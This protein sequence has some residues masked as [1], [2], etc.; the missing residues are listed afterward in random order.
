MKKFIFIFALLLFSA[1]IFS[2][3]YGNEWI[4]FNKTYYKIKVGKSGIYR[5][6]YNT[7]VS[8]GLPVDSINANQ[9]QLFYMGKQVPIY[10]TATGAMT[11]NDTIEFF[12]Q[13]NDGKY[14]KRL[15]ADSTWHT[16]DLVSMFSDTAVYFLTWDANSSSNERVTQFIND[17]TNPPAEE[18]Y[19]LYK[20]QNTYGN[21]IGGIPFQVISGYDLYSSEFEMAEGISKHA[22]WDFKPL[23]DMLPKTEDETIY[24]PFPYSSGDATLRTNV[25]SLT[26]DPRLVF[27]GTRE[28]D[29]NLSLNGN[30]LFNNIRF[31][32]TSLI[33]PLSYPFPVSFLTSINLPNS[34]VTFK[35]TSVYPDHYTLSWSFIEIEYPRLLNLDGK[36]TLRFSLPANGITS[37]RFLKFSNFGGTAVN[38]FLYDLTNKQRMIGIDDGSNNLLFVLSAPSNPNID[39]DI[40]LTYDET[41][42]INQLEAVQFKNFS[43]PLNQGDYIII[44][45]KELSSGSDPVQEYS[46]YRKS[47]K[48]GSY[49]P[50]IVDI[51]QL[52]DQFAYGIYRHPLSIHNFVEFALDSFSTVPQY[53]FMIGKGIDYTKKGQPGY[54]SIC[55]VPS[56]GNP[57][58]DVLL[59]SDFGR[60]APKL[61]VGR[62]SAY[63]TQD[64]ANYLKKVQAFDEN[65]INL[66][67]KPDN[68]DGRGFMKNIL[69][70][71][72]G[73]PN[74]QPTFKNY[75]QNYES[76]IE[77]TLFGGNVY[78]FFKTSPDP[79]SIAP[80]KF[81]DSLISSGLSIINF[82]GH[83]NANTFDF[84]ID[85]PDVYTNYGKYF[86]LISNGCYTGEIFSFETNVNSERFVLVEDKG[87]IAYLSSV[88]YGVS[89]ALDIFNTGLYEHLSRKSFGQSVGKCLQNSLQEIDAIYIGDKIV[90][91][92]AEQ[93]AYHGDPAISFQFNPLKQPD[94]Y[95]DRDRI[96]FSPSIISAKDSSFD[97]LVKVFNL[98]KAEGD[99]IDILI[100]RDMPGDQYDPL[101]LYFRVPATK[102]EQTYIVNLPRAVNDTL[103]DD[104]IGQNI[105]DIEIDGSYE[106]TEYDETNNTVS[107][108]LDILSNDAVPV[109]P[110]QFSIVPSDTVSLYA[111]VSNAISQ[112]SRNYIME[113]DTM[114]VG[115]LG[116]FNS[117]VKQSIKISSK[118]GV[119]QWK[120]KSSGFNFNNF[121]DSTVFYWRVSL[122]DSP[123]TWKY[124]SFIYLKNSSKGWNQSHYYQFKKD[125]FENMKLDIDIAS[126]K[127]QFISDAMDIG[128][129]NFVP[130]FG[131]T[132]LVWD[133][134][135]S[136]NGFRVTRGAGYI[137]SA[138]KSSGINFAIIDSATGILRKS[139]PEI[140]VIDPNFSE[141]FYSYGPTWD[142]LPQHYDSTNLDGTPNYDSLNKH[143]VIRFLDQQVKKGDYLL[144]YFINYQEPI[145]YNGN[146]DIMIKKF[147]EFGIKRL[148]EVFY[149]PSIDS[150]ARPYVFFAQKGHPDSTIEII[151][152]YFK[153]VIDTHFTIPQIWYQGSFQSDKIGPASNWRSLHWRHNGKDSPGDTILLSVYGIDKNGNDTLFYKFDDTQLDVGF[154]SGDIDAK[155][156]P[157]LRLKLEEKDDSMKTATQLKYWRVLYD[158]LPEAALNSNKNF[159]FEKDTLQQ[160]EPMKFSIA[161]ENISQRNMDSMLVRYIFTK[162]NGGKIIINKTFAPLLVNDTVHATFDTTLKSADF[163][164]RNQFFID[165]NPDNNQPEQFHFNNIGYKDFWV[166]GDYYNPLM[167]VTFDGYH[168]MDGDIVSA[169]PNIL[170]KLKDE[171]KYLALDDTSDFKITLLNPDKKTYYPLKFDNIVMRFTPADPSRLDKDNTAQIELNPVLTQ[172]GKYELVVSAT[173]KVGNQ[174]GRLDYKISFEVINRSMITN[175]LNYPNPF[176]TST[177]FVFTLTGYRIPTFF[178]IQILTITGKVVRE[179]MQNELGPLHIGRNETQFAWDGT[180]RYGDQ[181]ANGLYLYRVVV[182]IDGNKIEH[183][184]KELLDKYFKGGFGKMYL[185]R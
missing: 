108:K 86:L 159:V 138:N 44:S 93:D 155:K 141:A 24:T 60:F 136:V 176:T 72:G 67:N 64:V 154:P 63:T 92:T 183:Y 85:N 12:G 20:A 131:G 89:Y 8:A 45:H 47:L 19:C 120:P 112:V 59:G 125:K 135:F 157:Y 79:I 13:K 173:D 158:E 123:M 97:L 41:Y 180:D 115:S 33:K 61:A 40:F 21:L 128:I 162:Q 70:L 150:F 143:D 56:F 17:V 156:Y 35:G 179:I 101:H 174:A 132:K 77:D 98:G 49:N 163:R 104:G 181:L 23:D 57:P 160:G 76:I 169:R 177:K 7:L 82:F 42:S 4:D 116:T 53:L 129:I 27:G 142:C 52:Y 172:D 149:I 26:I 80:T 73:N 36:T 11:P 78:S 39:R 48:G 25:F 29:F 110:Y 22:R 32:N 148:K 133:I 119:I 130:G 124:S 6:F 83:S 113:I 94:Y 5:I 175:V 54:E 114:E 51:E 18:P 144:G 62:L 38:Y 106:K 28:C 50:I 145:R 91:M 140:S 122:V 99:S 74:E 147:E 96:T 117:P 37:K 71:G 84:S 107:V 185:I 151:G 65:I 102:H 31:N 30:D 182:S 146:I 43:N 88:D 164:G 170:I 109:Y 9:Y 126:R 118:G 127:F 178:K 58:S 15:F 166:T 184:E 34:T 167:D 153:S 10:I 2:K 152:D 121:K 81:I 171:N 55:L 100:K 66:P 69:H 14:D 161:M 87:A 111:S 137:N 1:S 95:I 103:G 165:M 68:P 168:I 134:M 16:Q 90:K 139:P 105:F 46:D 75:L 3:E